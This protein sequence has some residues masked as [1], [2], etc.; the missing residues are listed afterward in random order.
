MPRSSERAF[1]RWRVSND[2]A[3][4]LFLTWYTIRCSSSC[5]KNRRRDILIRKLRI[6]LGSSS[7]CH[8]IRDAVLQELTIA[9]K[10]NDEEVPTA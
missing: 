2:S 1:W 5:S 8:P 10:A 3:R 7:C 6:S 9:R 4:T